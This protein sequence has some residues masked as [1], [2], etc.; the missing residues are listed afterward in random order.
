MMVAGWLLGGFYYFYLV[1]LHLS[2]VFIH[3]GLFS[4]VAVVLMMI[5]VLLILTFLLIIYILHSHFIIL[6]FILL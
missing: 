1:T 6:F 3:V 4:P 2:E 5:I